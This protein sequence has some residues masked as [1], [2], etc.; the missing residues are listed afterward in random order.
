[1]LAIATFNLGRYSMEFSGSTAAWTAV[2]CGLVV[3]AVSLFALIRDF[4]KPNA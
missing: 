2:V 3:A 1:M 4:W